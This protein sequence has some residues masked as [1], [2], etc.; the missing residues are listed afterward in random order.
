[1]SWISC[2]VSATAS[3]SPSPFTPTI[4][5]SAAEVDGEV[6]NLA[7]ALLE[8]VMAK[9]KKNRFRSWKNSRARNGGLKS[10]HPFLDRESVLILA[11]YITLDT[12][13]GCVHTAPGHGQEDYESGLEYNLPIYSPVDDQG[14]FTAEVKFFAGQ[15]VFDAN[16]AVVRKLEGSGGPDLRENYTHQYPN[17]WRCKNP[18]IFRATEQW[19]SPWRGTGSAEALEAIDRVQWIPHWGKDRI[20]GMIQNRPDW[21]IS[22]QRAWGV[23]IVAFACASCGEVLTRQ[24]SV[25][26]SPVFSKKAGPMPGST[27]R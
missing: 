27:F 23:P 18:I 10:R 6:W 5:T 19:S 22:R 15:Y 25:E 16:E 24:S 17:C 13:T 2:G 1:M 21:C 12:G 9:A 14:R 7:E 20:Y 8:Q 3:S 11:R 26:Q 4:R